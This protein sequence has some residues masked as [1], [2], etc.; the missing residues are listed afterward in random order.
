MKWLS[1]H[2]DGRP[3][4]DQVVLAY[5]EA[6]KEDPRLAYRILDGQFVKICTGVTH[7]AYLKPPEIEVEE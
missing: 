3:N 5:S 6:Y 7:Y 4:R 2:K 1:I